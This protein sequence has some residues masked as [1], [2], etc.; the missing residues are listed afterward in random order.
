MKAK[1]A[2][3]SPAVGV[4]LGTPLEEVAQLMLERRIGS[5]LVLDE[6]GRLVGIVT[7]SDFLKE[8][9]IPFSTFR[10]PMFLGRYL[11]KDQMELLL[12][13]ARRTKVEE[14]MST[15]VHAVGPEEPLTRVLEIM[16]EYDV[17][18]VPVVDPEGKPLGI[19]T[20]FDLLRLLRPRL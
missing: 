8:R 3:T 10:A 7:E 15:P 11:G 12:A 6:A 20:R 13:E 2:M 9:G 19:I 14:I 18:H 5:V 17:N 1:D 4:P 16:L